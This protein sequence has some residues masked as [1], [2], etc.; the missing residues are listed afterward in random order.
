MLVGLTNDNLSEK[1]NINKVN[2]QNVIT[3]CINDTT[4]FDDAANAYF[5]VLKYG[6]AGNSTIDSI[7]LTDST[8]KIIHTFSNDEAIKQY[9]ISLNSSKGNLVDAME[10][11]ST[12][13]GTIANITEFPFLQGI[14]TSTG[15]YVLIND[16]LNFDKSHILSET[17]N[18]GIDLYGFSHPLEAYIFSEAKDNFEL[19][20]KESK[21]MIKDYQIQTLI[22]SF[23]SSNNRTNYYSYM[24]LTEFKNGFHEIIR[25]K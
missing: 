10:I 6:A 21:Q 18:L 19:T 16:I 20:A 11:V 9:A 1:F 7:S 17:I 23:S 5:G 3:V 13:T 14:S 4:G 8:G 12:M 24:F 22:N 15:G 2:N 25:G